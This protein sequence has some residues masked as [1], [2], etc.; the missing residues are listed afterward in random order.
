M[1]DVCKAVT[2]A[3]KY[4][5]SVKLSAN[6]TVTFWDGA[7][8]E[9]DPA[10]EVYREIHSEF[11]ETSK[12]SIEC[13]LSVGCGKK[14]PRTSSRDS[15][16]GIRE[17]S[18]IEKALTK[19]SE[20]EN[21]TYHRLQGP[22]D[23]PDIEE[24]FWRSDLKGEDTFKAMQDVAKR[25]CKR[26]DVKAELEDCARTL[27]ENRQR[28]ATTAGWEVFAGIRYRCLLCRPHVRGTVICENRGAFIEHLQLEHEVPPPDSKYYDEI[29]KLVSKWSEISVQ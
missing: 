26:K 5:K 4:F 15:S 13:L 9:S 1:T 10:M 12:A 7:S 18:Y 3:P 25:Y 11:P 21:F 6:K 29:Q 14:K 27:V 19:R 22:E 8:W 2:A 24:G 20:A 28:R 16:P 17:E 23:I